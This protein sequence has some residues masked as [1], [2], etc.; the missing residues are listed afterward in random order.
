[1]GG[2]GAVAA[3]RLE[4]LTVD[5]DF[6]AAGGHPPHVHAFHQFLYVR[7]GGSSSPRATGNTN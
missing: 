3:D 7:S 5:E 6:I 1:M 2:H 4:E